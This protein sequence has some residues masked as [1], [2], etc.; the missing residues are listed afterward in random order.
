M[1]AMGAAHCLAAA[2]V[3]DPFSSVLEGAPPRIL[4][5]LGR[6]TVSG[7]GVLVER[8]VLEVSAG[9]TAP[10]C[11]DNEVYC[12]RVTPDKAGVYP[13]MLLLHGGRGIA[14]GLRNAAVDWASRGYVVLAPELPGIADPEKAVYSKGE[15]RSMPYG[16]GRWIARPDVTA[17]TIFQGVVAALRSLALLRSDPHVDRSHVGVHGVSWGGYMTTMVCGLAGKDVA[18][19]FSMFGTGHFEQTSFG[20]SLSKM[21]PA[22]RARWYEVLDAGRR[23]GRIT[24]P[25]FVAAPC[26][27]HYFWPSAVEATLADIPGEAGRVYAPNVHHKM[28]VPGGDTGSSAGGLTS[29]MAQAFFDHWLKNK[30]APFPQ[31][32]V[33]EP[34]TTAGD[35][36]RVSFAVKGSW[37]PVDCGVYYS[38]PLPK[39]T[40]RA[41]KKLEVAR[42]ADGSYTATLPVRES[43][44]L[45]WFVLVSVDERISVSSKMM[46]W[47]Q[48]NQKAR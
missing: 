38:V 45:D 18:A 30:G 21:A 46:H 44:D 8:L 3:P 28:P 15:W 37:S 35:E 17:S 4:R 43:S 1:L 25:F 9:K 22:E 39:W 26:N 27:D 42:N 19:G 20:A 24:A 33:R 5:T 41:W 40:E 31:V 16:E 36:G 11:P 29:L 12:L 13:G 23:A 10:G 34:V 47:P 32:V 48:K 6:E 14:D 2:P 7:K